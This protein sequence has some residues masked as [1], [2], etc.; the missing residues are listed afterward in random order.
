V[1]L[2]FGKLLQDRSL[3]HAECASMQCVG[4]L[5]GGRFRFEGAIAAREAGEHAFAVRVLPHHP[6]LPDRFAA[7]LVAWQ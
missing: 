1:D 3:S 4:E 7:R 5:G 2:Y 6:G